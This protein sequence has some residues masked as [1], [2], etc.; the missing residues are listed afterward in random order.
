[1]LDVP[2]GVTG[3]RYKKVIT[4]AVEAYIL[5]PKNILYVDMPWF[6]QHFIYATV[7]DMPWFNQHFIYA[8]V[9]FYVPTL[10]RFITIITK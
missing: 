3:Y 4:T 9:V 8:I 7:V 1:M 5:L 10:Q 6:N 2:N